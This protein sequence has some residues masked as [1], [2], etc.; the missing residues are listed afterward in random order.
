MRRLAWALAG[1]VLA[2]G[3]SGCS[4]DELEDVRAQASPA[5]ARPAARV[6]VATVPP[7]K[8][9]RKPRSK[10]VRP[11]HLRLWHFDARVV[12]IEPRED[13]QLVPPSD[14]QVLGWWGS[15]VGAARGSTVIT[16]HTIHGG[17]AELDDLGRLPVGAVG[18]VSGVWYRVVAVDQMG[19]EDLPA[20][21][22][23][24]E[25]P[26]RLYLITCARYSKEAGHHLDNVVATLIRAD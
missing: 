25:G 17:D 21:V 11:E 6:V 1:I 12:P 4:A 18:D 5:P 24:Q 9:A 10:P 13:G 2:A 14:A 19:K 16:G 3:V 20:R 22:F 8:S 26:H 7:Q 23:D 15:K